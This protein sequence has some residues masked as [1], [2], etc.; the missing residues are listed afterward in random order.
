MSD[1]TAEAAE[2]TEEAAPAEP[3]REEGH[4][5]PVVE[6]HGQRVVFVD[7]NGYLDLLKALR[8]D[9]Y[10][11]CIDV[12]AVDYL[13]HPNRLVPDGIAAERFEV[14]VN[15]LDM[16]ERRR[17]RVRCPVPADDPCLPSLFD[18]WPGSDLMER[19]VYAL[20]GIRFEGHP[21]MTRLFMPDDWEGHPLRKDYAVGRVPVQ[22]KDAPP[23][24]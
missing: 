22:F 24:R 3:E 14:V 6:S 17:I 13:A 18:E 5:W 8:Q 1:Q 10:A 20:M 12:A 4:G 23:P 15:L 16:H 19:E 21:D 2:V 7:R 11:M 9:G